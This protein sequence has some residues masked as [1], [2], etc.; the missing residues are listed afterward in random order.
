MTQ[1]VTRHGQWF[2]WHLLG[3]GDLHYIWQATCAPDAQ[4][5]SNWLAEFKH[6]AS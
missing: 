1:E 5:A 6:R 4:P 3:L 2:V